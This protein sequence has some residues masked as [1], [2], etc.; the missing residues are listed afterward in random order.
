MDPLGLVGQSLGEYTVGAF[1]DNGAFGVVHEG[2]HP[3]AGSGIALKVLRPGA[4]PQSQLEF[5]NEGTLLVRLSSAS[6][7]VDIVDTCTETVSVTLPF[8][9]SM[10]VPIKFHVLELAECCL[11]D[12]VVNL[13]ELDWVTRLSLFRDVVLGAHQLH[14]KGI[15]HRDLKAGNVLVFEQGSRVVAKLNDFGRSRD[16]AAAPVTT[17]IYDFGRGDPDY[18]APEFLWGVGQDTRS[19]HVAADLYGLGSVFVELVLGVGITGL[20]V[21]PHLSMVMA[22]HTL[23]WVDRQQSY[24]HRLAEVRSWYAPHFD[25]I[26]SA[27]PGAIRQQAGQLIRQLCDPDPLQRFPKVAPG[28]RGPR[29]GELTWILRRVDAMTKSLNHAM[30]EANRLAEKKAARS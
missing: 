9:G 20:A 19:T 15:V 10:P 16:L 26:E 5:Q 6:R 8:G 3:R 7:I 28:R 30:R 4:D 13:H 17:A 11:T 1:R 25:F 22:H 2:S 24:L 21:S 23:P 27:V 29:P 12:L 14:L 18:A